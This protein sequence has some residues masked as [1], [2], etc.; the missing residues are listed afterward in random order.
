MKRARDHSVSIFF[1]HFNPIFYN[2]AAGEQGVEVR[3]FDF[4]NHDGTN[5]VYFAGTAASIFEW[6]Y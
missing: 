4:F 2:I 6:T 3:T 5:K 1:V